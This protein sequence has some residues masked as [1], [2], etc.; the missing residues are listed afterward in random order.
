MA[1]LDLDALEQ[2]ARDDVEERERLDDERGFSADVLTLLSRLRAAEERVRELEAAL[3]KQW[4]EGYDDGYGSALTDGAEL[5]AVADSARVVD[6]AESRLSGDTVS[7]LISR[8][9]A[10]EERAWELEA[11]AVKL[12]VD[13]ASWCLERKE[14]IARHGE[15]ADRALVAEHDLRAVAEAAREYVLGEDD[16]GDFGRLLRLESRLAALDAAKRGTP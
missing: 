12:R 3:G 10:A 4:R 2:D 9:R 13:H 6:M 16:D 1:D 7:A 14:L 5:R 8:L 15:L 11:E